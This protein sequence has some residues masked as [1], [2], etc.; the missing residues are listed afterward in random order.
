MPEKNAIQAHI[1]AGAQ[2]NRKS[3]RHRTGHLR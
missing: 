3:L 1:P 2:A